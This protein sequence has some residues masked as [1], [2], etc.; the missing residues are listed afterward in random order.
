MNKII[1]FIGYISF[2]IDFGEGQ[3]LNCI[4]FINL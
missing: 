2:I 1:Y 3:I 4:L